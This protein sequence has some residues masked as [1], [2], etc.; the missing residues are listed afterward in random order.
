MK[1]RNIVFSGFAAAILMGTAQ[2]ATTPFEIAS[3]AYVDGKFSDATSA[4]TEIIGDMDTLNADQDQNSVV[5]GSETVVDALDALDEAVTAKQNYADSTASAGNYI[6]AGNGVGANLNALDTQL[7]T[8]TDKANG[9]VPREMNGS[10]GKA[11]IFNENDGGGAK[12]E[13]SDGIN[14]FTGVN[15]G[16]RN[17][18]AAQIYAVDTNNNVGGVNTG[19]RIDVYADGMYYTVGHDGSG[20]RKAAANEIATK[21]DITEA[22]NDAVGG[23]VG[24]MDELNDGA[25]T[26]FD[27][28]ESVVDALNDL[29]D[30]INTK[31]NEADS[32]VASAGN[33]I[34]AGHGVASNL[35][36]LDTQ[37]KSTTDTANA[38]VPRQMNGTNGKAL[39]FNENDGGGAK[40]EHND[41]TYS[42]TGVNDDGANGIAAQIYAIDKTSKSGT[43]IDVSKG[44]IYYTVGNAGAGDRMVPANEIATKGDIAA[45]SGDMSQLNNGNDTNFDSPADVVEALN[46]LDDAINTKADASDVGDVNDLN[47]FAQNTNTVVDALNELM[48]NKLNKPIPN[49]CTAQSQHCVLHMDNTGELSWVDITV[50][51]M[52]V[53]GGE[54]SGGGE[55]PANP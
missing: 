31:Q 41:G 14:S 24:D 10:A 44:A 20:A 55:E 43:R 8:T 50:P 12:F 52:E 33:Y 2:A 47:G 26:N 38:A 40:F 48:T 27:N 51:Y 36:A 3:K 29:D 5:A 23:S 25:N 7:K 39:I 11:L 19:A 17:G 46:D 16:G 9:A 54:Q 6:T 28:P 35:T 15:E 34:A 4:T 13:N 53:S 1:V 21:G 22:L 45:V 49:S 18:I 37:L 42:F 30:A 32:N